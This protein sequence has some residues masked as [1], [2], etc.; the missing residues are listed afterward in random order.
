M[1]W[2]HMVYN[3]TCGQGLILK[4]QDQDQDWT[5]Q[6]QDQ[7]QDWTFQDQDQ[8]QDLNFGPEDSSGPGPVLRTASL[9][10]TII[11]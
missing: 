3:Q 4:D 7:D 1:Q 6:D 10:T 5:F 2:T 11:V 8:D 9:I